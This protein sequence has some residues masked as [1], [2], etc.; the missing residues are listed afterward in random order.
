MGWLTA[1]FSAFIP[2]SAEQAMA[3]RDLL[4]KAAN[5][6]TDLIGI[7]RTAPKPT[8]KHSGLMSTGV[9]DDPIAGAVQVE[10]DIRQY[11]SKG[12]SS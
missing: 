8:V 4:L 1:L 11:L 7:A 5:V 12:G 6:I 10:Q 9:P 3:E 2:R